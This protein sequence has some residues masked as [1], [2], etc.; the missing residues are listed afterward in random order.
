VFVC[1]CHGITEDDV[2]QLGARG[3]AHADEIIACF[4][5]DSAGS[6]GRCLRD[7]DEFEALARSGN[8]LP[9]LPVTAAHDGRARRDGT[10]WSLNPASS[11]A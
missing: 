3:V 11:I 6:C 7:I 9:R 5:L 10:Q 4:N 2:R 8:S 1:S